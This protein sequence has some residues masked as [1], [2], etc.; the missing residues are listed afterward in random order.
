MFEPLPMQIRQERERQGLSQLALANLADVS[1]TSI[2]QLEKGEDNISLGVLVKIA[3]ALKMKRLFIADLSFE[4]GT[5]DLKV[6]LVARGALAAAE[7]VADQV[8]DQAIASRRD[9]AR[10]SESV[11]SLLHSAFDAEPVP[12][13]GIARAARR[14]ASRPDTRSTERALREL[15]E[16]SDDALPRRSARAKTAPQAAAR[17]QGR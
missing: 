12:D 9:L 1:R 5:P 16:E 14:L 2:V 6:L 13:A 10:H 17:K 15:A 11:A 4:A 8:A 3:R 7:Q